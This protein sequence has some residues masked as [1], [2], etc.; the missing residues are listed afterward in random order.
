MVN[1]HNQ[2]LEAMG[3]TM[4]D[5][6]NIK[7]DENWT[8]YNLSGP[9]LKDAPIILIK[10]GPK[11]IADV[12]KRTRG[13]H[14][15]VI[16]SV[17]LKKLF[18]KSL[19]KSYTVSFDGDAEYERISGII[20]KH[21]LS[22]A[23]NSFE[24]TLVISKIIDAIPNT[25]GEFENRGLF[26]THYLRNRLFDDFIPTI[27]A[28][29]LKNAVK[30]P[31]KMLSTLGWK[32]DNGMHKTDHAIV[33]ITEQNDFSTR[34]KDKDV[35]PSYLAVTKLISNRWVILTNGRKWRL[36]TNKISASSTNYFEIDIKDLSDR[37]FLYLTALFE[38]Y[39][40]TLL[41]STSLI[42]IIGASFNFGPLRL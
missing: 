20:K 8:C 21:D 17:N 11:N 22:D 41:K 32:S 5:V 2:L 27:H 10:D 25:I 24:M 23:Q 13:Y 34:D 14:A 28:D 4:T 3:V 16:F 18:L 33:I 1:D 26:S 6:P 12:K 37:K 30:D 38:R 36:Y 40:V 7:L 31:N 35:T 29:D 39:C 15:C 19:E 42:N 9:K